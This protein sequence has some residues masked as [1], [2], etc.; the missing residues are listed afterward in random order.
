[1]DI[2]VCIEQSDK[3]LLHVIIQ[4]ALPKSANKMMRTHWRGN[5]SNLKRWKRIIS[6]AVRPFAPEEP[7]DKI[8][9]TA[10]RHNYRFL[11]Y[12]GLVTSL[13]GPIDGVKGIIFTDD[14]YKVTGPWDVRQEFRAKNSGPVLELFFEET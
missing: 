5:H 12:D 9:I 8:K 7:F 3:Y 2:S 13:K 11:D 6:D 14:S 10:I 1:M 4:G